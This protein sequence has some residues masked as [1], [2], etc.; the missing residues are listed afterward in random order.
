MNGGRGNKIRRGEVISSP[1]GEDIQPIRV[2]LWAR[3]P[4]PL[5]PTTVSCCAWAAQEGKGV[6][7]GEQL[8][9]TGHT[10]SGQL[11]A[12]SPSLKWGQDSALA[13]GSAI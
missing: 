8:S 3:I 13:L 11:E 2:V 10:W 7:L 12:T 6:P 9:T 4:G 1:H 5:Y